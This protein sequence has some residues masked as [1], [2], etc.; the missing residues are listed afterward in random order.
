MK[1]LEYMELH[2]DETV[3]DCTTYADESKTKFLTLFFGK[4]E[5]IV[6]GGT[7][8]YK[9]DKSFALELKRLA[10]EV[11][12]SYDFY[13]GHSDLDIALDAMYQVGCADCPHCHYCDEMSLEIE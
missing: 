3:Y 10:K 8:I 6:N 7:E 5:V 11:N 4:P 1:K 13:R 9:N 2:P 12:E